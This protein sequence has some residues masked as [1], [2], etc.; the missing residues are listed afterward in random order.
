MR[1][2]LSQLADT[3]EFVLEGGTS[4]AI[5][6]VR[7]PR[8]AARI[9]RDPDG[10][11]ALAFDA[12]DL[13]SRDPVLDDTGPIIVMAAGQSN[14]IG[15]G[16][17]GPMPVREDVRYWDHTAGSLSTV[18]LSGSAY[19]TQSKASIG[20]GRN[21]LA[22]AFAVQ[23][24]EQ[25]GRTVLLTIEGAG[26]Q[27]LD[28]WIGDGTASPGYVHSSRAAASLLADTG[29]THVDFFLWHQGESDAAGSEPYHERFETLLGQFVADG[30]IDPAATRIIAGE[31]TSLYAGRGNYDEI[32]ALDTL[33][34]EYLI[35]VAPAGGLPTLDDF[36]FDGPALWE[37]GHERYWS[38][39]L[40]LNSRIY[41]VPE[42]QDSMTLTIDVAGR[43][44][45]FIFSSDGSGGTQIMF[46]DFFP[47][48]A[49]GL[50]SAD[51]VNGIVSPEYLTGATAPSF[52]IDLISAD[53]AFRNTLGVYEVRADGTIVDVRII[54]ADA[55][56]I[57]EAITVS[58]VEEG[59]SL[60]F[61]LMPDG[62]SLLSSDVLTSDSL[63]IALIGSTPVL[64]H[65]GRWILSAPIFISHDASLNPG[66]APHVLSGVADDG[67][68]AMVIGFEDM[69]RTRGSD[70][71]FQDLVI[72]VEAIE[73]DLPLFG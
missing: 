19:P 47:S 46:A 35:E 65:E 42:G 72:R 56:A 68:G 39:F 50:S 58:G 25:T 1:I 48:L 37:F 63:G 2:T 61:F 36:H 22:V 14:M 45:D 70:D 30:I 7:L 69:V 60:G 59:N 10:T 16:T 52:T 44:G 18:D 20:G 17:G 13:A 33:L 43:E 66:G 34:P 51:A 29:S 12:A 23:L 53:A 9:E 24:N 38:A 8:A 41:D 21:N 26:G 32:A 73:A 11:F 3:P 55:G 57:S 62:A 6:G 40:E 27:S 4:L 71:D 31:I 64:T 67:S 15:V 49:E 54:A 28:Y 5:T